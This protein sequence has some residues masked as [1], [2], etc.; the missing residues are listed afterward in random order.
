MTGPSRV[1]TGAR[2]LGTDIFQAHSR[3]FIAWAYA[4]IAALAINNVLI[5]TVTTPSNTLLKTGIR[6]AVIFCAILIIYFFRLEIPIIAL[7][8]ALICAAL[9]LLRENTDQLSCL[10]I[11]VIFP[12]LWLIP[13][14]A[15]ARA[16]VV[17]SYASF[18]LIIALL[19]TGVTANEVLEYRQRQTFGTDGIPFLMN[20]VY[21]AA[22]LSIYYAIR[23]ELKSR[24]FVTVICVAY[25]YYFYVNSDGR[26]GLYFL[27]LFVALAFTMPIIIRNP[28][29]SA[30]IALLP[31]ILLGA[32]FWLSLQA[33]DA[34][35]NSLLSYRPERYSSFMNSI[36]TGDLLFGQSVKESDRIKSL[37]NSYLHLLIGLS[38]PIFIL[39]CGTWARATHSMALKR[40][41]TELA[42]ICATAAY[43]FS[44]SI[45]LRTE[46]V[47]ILF[48]WVLILQF[49]ASANSKSSGSG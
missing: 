38:L 6:A 41:P 15:L 10:Y 1:E 12:T 29:L 31:I 7:Y 14:R 46:N 37:D 26:G 35:L 3:F 5:H 42:F 8:G 18:G 36:S 32:A 44:E 13:P 19:V 48:F 4:A 39:V 17:C 11:L 30:L 24:Y 34:S 47:F 20:I 22:A 9:M 28:G 2:A 45:L 23:Y 49:S 27:L 33:K 40:R 43:G 25:T 21:G 16:A